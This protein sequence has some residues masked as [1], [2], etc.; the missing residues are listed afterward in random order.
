MA[1]H[2][3][4]P[5]DIVARVPAITGADRVLPVDPD[6]PADVPHEHPG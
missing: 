3:A 4:R 6:V 1:L 5:A 2:L